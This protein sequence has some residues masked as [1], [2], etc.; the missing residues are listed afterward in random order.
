MKITILTKGITGWLLTQKLGI[1]SVLWWPRE[2][3]FEPKSWKQTHSDVVLTSEY[4]LVTL[5]TDHSRFSHCINNWK[6][7]CSFFHSSAK[8]PLPAPSPF[9]SP[10]TPRG[11]AAVRLGQFGPK[12]PKNKCY[13]ESR[14]PARRARCAAAPSSSQWLP[15]APSGSQ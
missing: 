15:V 13:R 12:M 3:V 5:N 1:R 6:L 8:P 14:L 9:T 4:I 11:A 2:G 7:F 10:G